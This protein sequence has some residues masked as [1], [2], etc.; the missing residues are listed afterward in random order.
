MQREVEDMWV[1]ASART[2]SPVA[3]VRAEART[4][5]ILLDFCAAAKLPLGWKPMPRSVAMAPLLLMIPG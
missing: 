3:E 4:H 5:M 1:R 2:E